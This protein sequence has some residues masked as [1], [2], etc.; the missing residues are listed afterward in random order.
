MAS[1][2]WK[3]A[4]WLSLVIGPII[5]RVLTALGL[6]VVTYTGIEFALDQFKD[7]ISNSWSGLPYNVASILGMAGFDSAMTI[8]ISAVVS[9][10]GILVVNGAIKKIGF[11][12]GGGGAA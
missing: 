11:T 2:F 9:A 6:G 7:H 5:A 1:V 8:I 3:I 10:Y 12:K 4:A